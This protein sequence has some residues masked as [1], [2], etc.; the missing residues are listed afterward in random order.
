[1]SKKRSPQD[2]RAEKRAAFEHLRAVA[3]P[4]RFRAIPDVEGFPILPGRYGQ[5]E[6]FDG[7]DLAVYSDR[8]RL[9]AKIWAVPGVRRPPLAC[10]RG[11][12]RGSSSCEA[13]VAD[14]VRTN[15][16]SS[17][18]A[19][20]ELSRVASQVG[21]EASDRVLQFLR[22]GEVELRQGT[23]CRKRALVCIVWRRRRLEVRIGRRPT[24]PPEE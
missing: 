9:F 14:K 12:S 3:R 4:F 10:M 11:R 15:S 18:P 22:L 16:D 1:M 21:L 5:I 6:W 20:S 24:P 2:P 8:P 13:L 19:Q 23:Q 17:G 7:Q